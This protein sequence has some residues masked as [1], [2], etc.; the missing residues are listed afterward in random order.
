MDLQ[1]IEVT[2]PELKKRGAQLV[3]ISPQ[4]APNSRRSKRDN[5]ISFPILSDRRND[6]A[7]AF[8]RRFTLP[9]YL[10]DLYKNTFKNDLEVANGD[11]SWTLPMPARFVIGQDGIIV[12]SEVNPD[13][14]RRPD[15]EALIPVLQKM[16]HATV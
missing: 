7:A 15:P 12:Y 11:P 4:T 1:A 5:N 3:A 13:Y 8:G 14:T 16:K 2:L 10:Q 9:C 6:V